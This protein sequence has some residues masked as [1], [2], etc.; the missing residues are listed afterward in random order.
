MQDPV[1][2]DQS[3]NGHFFNFHPMK[4]PPSHGDNLPKSCP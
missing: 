1:A 4:A 3:L 2:G